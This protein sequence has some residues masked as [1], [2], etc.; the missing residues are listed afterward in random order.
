MLGFQETT[1]QK[2]WDDLVAHD[3]DH[4]QYVDDDLKTLDKVLSRIKK[5]EE[6]AAAENPDQV[7]QTPPTEGCSP[8]LCLSF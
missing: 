7:P 2:V 5:I 8:T 4:G 6:E 1:N 3:T